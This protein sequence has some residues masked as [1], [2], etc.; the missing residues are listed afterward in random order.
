VSVKV[1]NKDKFESILGDKA[2]L[3]GEV[4]DKD[5]CLIDII[6]KKLLK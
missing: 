1:N 6:I 2:I 3:L 4:T 5:E